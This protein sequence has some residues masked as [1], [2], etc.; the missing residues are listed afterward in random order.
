MYTTDL[1]YGTETRG[2]LTH[3]VGDEIRDEHGWFYISDDGARVIGR[4][5]NGRNHWYVAAREDVLYFTKD[6]A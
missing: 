1:R 6:R 5:I 4:K 2:T 3:M